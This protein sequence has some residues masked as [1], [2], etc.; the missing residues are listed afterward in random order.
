[1]KKVD[2]L[3]NDASEAQGWLFKGGDDQA[4]VVLEMRRWRSRCAPGFGDTV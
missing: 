4:L 3:S 1:M 2:S